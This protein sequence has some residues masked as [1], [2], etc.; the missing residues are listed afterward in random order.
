MESRFEVWQNMG[1]GRVVLK[2]F[3]S[4]G[5]VTHEIISGGKT[6]HLTPEERVLNQEEAASEELDFFK[7]GFLAPVRLLDESDLAE[8]ADNPNIM[9][10]EDIRTLFRTKSNWKKFDETVQGVSNVIL[11]DRMLKMAEAED[12]TVRQ[13][14]KIHERISEISPNSVTDVESLS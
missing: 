13:V 1:Q 10:E 5:R 8:T 2:K 3:D 12:A 4:R 6:V 9:S 7:N 11:L 14:R